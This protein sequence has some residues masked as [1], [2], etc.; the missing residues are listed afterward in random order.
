MAI[1]PPRPAS[2][3]STFRD[4][5]QITGWSKIN[6]VKIGDT[7]SVRANWLCMGWPFCLAEMRREFQTGGNYFCTTLYLLGLFEDLVDGVEL[8][9]EHDAHLPHRLDLLQEGPGNA[10]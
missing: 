5:A 10:I 4:H 7:C 3:T 2:A 1:I 6:G 9:V 8:A